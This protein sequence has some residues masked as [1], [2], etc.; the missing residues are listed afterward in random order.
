MA[1]ATKSFPPRAIVFNEGDHADNAFIVVRGSVELVVQRSGK[2]ITIDTI[3]QGQCFGEMGPLSNQ[4]RICGARTREP[5]ELLPLGA[6]DLRTTLN[7]SD[8]VAR[9]VVQ[10]LVERIRKLDEDAIQG[11]SPRY[12]LVS[13]ARMLV[14][15]ANAAQSNAPKSAEP[16]LPPLRPS[17][18]TPPPAGEHARLPFEKTVEAMADILGTVGYRL[19]D[20]LKQMEDLNLISSESGSGG[21]FIRF[22]AA[23]LVE[24]ATRLQASL[25]AL[26]EKRMTAEIELC[27]LEQLASEAGLDADKT[28]RKLVA[29][30]VPRE[31]FLFRRQMAIDLVRRHGTDALERRRMKRPEEFETIDDIE[32]LDD[33]S[34]RTA[35]VRLE[36]LDQ[37][38]LVRGSSQAVAAR[39]V[40]TLSQRIREIVEKAAAG[41][42]SVDEIKFRTLERRLL[43]AIKADAAR[44]GAL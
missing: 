9:T 11:F 25:G 8:P 23:E 40:A 6:D 41:L 38:V 21:R 36:T 32:F 14:L 2:T 16:K 29:G 20:A 4:R 22:R 33:D 17:S 43:D 26:L 35:F 12:S 28:F 15:F 34:L 42:T 24:N 30:E 5:T 39:L 31:L 27:D 18:S 1:T 3:T 19:K 37:A 13:L 44:G 10:A 7:Q